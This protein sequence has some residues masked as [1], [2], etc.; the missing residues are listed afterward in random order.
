[1]IVYFLV[2]IVLKGI[3][4]N[5]LIIIQSEKVDNIYGFKVLLV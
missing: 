3:E 4:K 2:K 5:K 1:M